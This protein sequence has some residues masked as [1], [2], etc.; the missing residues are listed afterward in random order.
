MLVAHKYSTRHNYFK[1]NCQLFYQL[2]T[3]KYREYKNSMFYQ[4][5]K[6]L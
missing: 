3:T 6:L 5:R 1:I 4:I 2:Y